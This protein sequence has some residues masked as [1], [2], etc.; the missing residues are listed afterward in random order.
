MRNALRQTELIKENQDLKKELAGRQG[1]IVGE[2][3]KL[4]AVLETARK[5]A[6]RDIPVLITG[7]SGTG[8][9]LVARFLH[10]QSPRRERKFFAVNCGAIPETLLES[11]LFGHRKGAF[12]SADRDH[13]G[14][15][16]AADSGTLFLDEVGTL[17]LNVQKTL[18]RFLQEQEFY[19]VGDTTPM[20]VDVR[21]ISATNRD[22]QAAVQ[23]GA[24]RDDLYYRLN[25]INL[26]LPPLREHRDDI[27]LLVA[28]FIGEQNRRFGIRIRGFTPEAMEALHQYDWQGNVRQLSNV[29][30]AA[31]AIA[32]SDYIGLDILA[33]FI[34]LPDRPVSNNFDAM[35]Y[36][37]A[38]ARFEVDYLRQLLKKTGGVVEDIAHQAGM[39]VATIYRK[40]KKYG[41]RS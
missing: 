31:M 1:T 32:G 26:H 29:I 17:P 40:M 3:P 2:S 12:T 23:A 8:K 22:L 5:V 38:L 27:P 18:L 36:E 30:Q 6:V 14:I 20:R 39:N 33:Q 13:K 34:E 16:E 28:H 37:A 21:V 41:L 10:E 25:V 35:D 9:E 19:R 24:F 7:E 15:L 11:E 4:R